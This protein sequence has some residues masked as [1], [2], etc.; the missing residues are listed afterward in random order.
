MRQSGGYSPTA[1][2]TKSWESFRSF[3][4]IT[5]LL[6]VSHRVFRILIKTAPLSNTDSISKKKNMSRVFC[7][8][9]LKQKSR[10]PFPVLRLNK[11]NYIF[12]R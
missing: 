2:V 3:G 4:G 8:Y 1:Q 5:F 7:F 12:Y 9:S 10:G 6:P 11:D